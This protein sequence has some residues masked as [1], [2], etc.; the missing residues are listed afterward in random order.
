MEQPG[1]GADLSARSAWQGRLQ[2]DQTVPCLTVYRGYDPANNSAGRGLRVVTGQGFAVVSYDAPDRVAP[3]CDL[4]A[5]RSMIGEGRLRLRAGCSTYVSVSGN[6]DEWR[7]SC[8]YDWISRR[9][10]ATF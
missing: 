7:R 9:W 2:V 6:D 10:H 4:W 5:G 8:D 1:R 3:A